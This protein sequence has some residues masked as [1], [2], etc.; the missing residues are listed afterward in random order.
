MWIELIQCCG[1]INLFICIDKFA[2]PKEG[3]YYFVHAICNFLIVLYTSLDVYHLY[4]DPHTVF[5]VS[6][7]IPLLLTYALH[8]YHIIWYFH[9]LQ[10]NDLLHHVLMVMIALPLANYF[11]CTRGLNHTL[12]YT[13]GLP[14]LI[15]YICLTCVRNGFMKRITEKTINRYL[16]LWIRCPGCVVHVY[17]CC[18][19]SHF[20]EHYNLNTTLEIAMYIIPNVL[21][22]WNGIYF[23]DQVI[24]NYYIEL[25][26]KNIH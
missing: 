24:G 8:L 2:S 19:L 16:N 9:K 4:R 15:D 7:T 25:Y 26:K 18:F 6:Y 13:S 14:G 3:K 17:I 11:G 1:F 22:L 20:Q 5:M 10:F 12:F 21:V 23:M